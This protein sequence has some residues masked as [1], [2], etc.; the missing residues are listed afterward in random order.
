MIKKFALA[1]AIAL[2]AVGLTAG[3]ANAVPPTGALTM[4]QLANF[5]GEFVAISEGLI[6]TGC[7]ALP[8]NLTAAR[9]GTL[10]VT[11]TQG[12]SRVEFFKGA[13]CTAVNR[14]A[15]L[16]VTAPADADFGPDAALLYQGFA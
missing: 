5:D 13:S 15:T 9:S 7:T 10:E 14:V 4:H 2:A 1:S 11:G 16:T 6:Q 8:A 12:I 3:A